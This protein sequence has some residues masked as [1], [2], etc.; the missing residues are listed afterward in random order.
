[1]LESPLKEVSAK[2]L[3]ARLACGVWIRVST[4]RG[5]LW[6]P[7][8]KQTRHPRADKERM[9]GEMTDLLGVQS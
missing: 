2:Y 5:L 9:L 6:D 7:S 4:L 1:M 8:Q 3:G